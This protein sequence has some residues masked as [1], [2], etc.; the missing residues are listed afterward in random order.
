MSTHRCF[1]RAR[2]AG[3]LVSTKETATTTISASR[4]S[5]AYKPALVRATPRRPDL[6]H[7]DAGRFSCSRARL[8]SDDL[9]LVE[10][11]SAESPRP[12]RGGHAFEL[13]S[14]CRPT[15]LPARI[16]RE[17][18]R[19]LRKPGSGHFLRSYSCEWILRIM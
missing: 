4:P 2:S 12:Q 3:R 14:I 7:G 11:F 6:R 9:W 13:E 1:Q 15:A 18:S 19:V 10:V 16:T 5:L 17:P 8:R